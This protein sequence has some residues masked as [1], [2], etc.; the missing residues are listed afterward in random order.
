MLLSPDEPSIDVGRIAQP[1][2]H[3]GA[4]RSADRDI[5]L[6]RGFRWVL[7][8]PAYH[9]GRG[10]GPDQDVLQRCLGPAIATTQDAWLFDLASRAGQ[11]CAPVHTGRR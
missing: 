10:P 4:L 7:V 5:L 11:D 3:V 6:D 8:Y 1:L 9:R 2:G